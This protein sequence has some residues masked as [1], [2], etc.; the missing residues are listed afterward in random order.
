LVQQ[1]A[2]GVTSKPLHSRILFHVSALFVVY[3]RETTTRQKSK[4]QLRKKG[5]LV[6]WWK[7]AFISN[8]FLIMPVRR[9]SAMLMLLIALKEQTRLVKKKRYKTWMTSER[10]FAGCMYIRLNGF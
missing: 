9:I 8:L 5:F 1:R 3:D 2:K 4:Q 7:K 10:P 6:F